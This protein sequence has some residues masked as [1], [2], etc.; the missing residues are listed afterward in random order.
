MSGYAPLDD[1]QRPNVVGD[2]HRSLERAHV[3][4][5]LSVENPP[6][7]MLAP[8]PDHAI[9]T[10]VPSEPTRPANPSWVRVD[11]TTCNAA[12]RTRLSRM[13]TA[14]GN[15][16]VTP[17][18]AVAPQWRGQ[19]SRQPSRN[20]IGPPGAPGKPGQRPTNP[21]VLALAV[22]LRDVESRRARGNVL[23]DPAA[24]EPTL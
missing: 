9:S 2:Q 14:P 21:V 24:K 7:R 18:R 15:T 23:T 16:F 22:A 12:C 5:S 10:D 6:G 13:P 20:P 8:H 1:G 4:R 17:L 3:G 11:K 19:E